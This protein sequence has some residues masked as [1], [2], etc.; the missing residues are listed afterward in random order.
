MLNPEDMA[1]INALDRPDG[2]TLPQPEEMNTL[3]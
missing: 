1:G 3:F 2:K